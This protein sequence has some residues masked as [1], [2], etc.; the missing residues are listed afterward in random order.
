MR[1][2]APSPT[3]LL[4]AIGAYLTMLNLREDDTY[5]WLDMCTI[6]QHDVS[7]EVPFISNVMRELGDALVVLD[8]WDK[9]VCLSRVW[10]LFEVAHC[11]LAGLPLSLGVPPTQRSLPARALLKRRVAI[12]A[13]YSGFDARS[14]DATV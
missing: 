11:T 5:L 3:N 4:G 10:C 14:A 7:A 9:P 8:P 1:S 2:R 12:D 6:R 13:V